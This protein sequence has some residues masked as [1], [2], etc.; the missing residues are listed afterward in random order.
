MYLTARQVEQILRE[1]GSLTLPFGARLTP[2]AQ[3]VIRARKVDLRFDAAAMKPNLTTNPV[4]SAEGS[5]LWWAGVQSGT[6]KAALAM[7]AR[8]AN[9]SEAA[10][11]ED[12]SKAV[13]AVRAIASAI[14]SNS[15]AGAI[16]VVESAG[17]TSVLCNRSPA[18]RA[19]VGTSIASIDA[20]IRDVAANVLIIEPA[21]H[22]MM[23]LKNMISR[24]IRTPRRLDATIEHQLIE[25][26]TG[27]CPCGSA[28]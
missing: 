1:Q 9:L 21:T 22:S 17:L 7:V 15:S 12:A 5:Y 25:L 20:G 28:K 14:K 3:D 6:A 27:G 19:I 8:E 16:L 2:A 4:A 10:I 13:S 23:S 11:L 24:F 18:L 26:A